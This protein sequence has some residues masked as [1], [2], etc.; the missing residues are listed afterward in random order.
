MAI[1][2]IDGG[3]TAAT[4]FTAAGAACGVKKS[5]ALDIAMIASEPAAK[6][7]AMFTTNAVKAAPV[8][9][10]MARVGAKR[11]GGI[12]ISSGNANACT[13]AQGVTDA[14]R[15]CETA[16][17][18]CG[19][20]DQ[21]FLVASTGVIGTYLPIEKILA[22]IKTT[23][24]LLSRTGHT[25]AAAAIMTTDTVIKESAVEI[26]VGRQLVRI[27]GMAKGVG[28]IA[29]N[30][31]TMI[32][33]VTTDADICR[34][35]LETTI[36]AAVEISFNCVTIDGDMSTNDTVFVLANGAAGNT[37]ILRDTKAA[38]TFQAGLAVVMADLAEQMVRDGEE[39]TKF[40][41]V[42]V[43]GADCY[44]TAKKI[45]MKIAE[46]VLVKCALFGKDANWGRIAAAAGAADV[47]FDPRTMG[48]AING[49]VIMRDG[50]AAID[51]QP[52]L[53]AAMR[54][55]DIEITL[56]LKQGSGAASVLTTDLSVGYVKFNAHYRT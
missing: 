23:G 12:V 49:L 6:A 43:E 30:M 44:G 29:P 20:A 5:G 42:T 8:V 2:K 10:S 51:N 21:E 16:A 15:M 19:K 27:G 22:G 3:V 39:A 37:H 53:D 18:V 31:A 54:E 4:G 35:A 56:D 14:E 24:R 1:K 50:G 25:A 41:R 38:E 32:A 26:M 9:V 34:Q 13:G 48:I 47:E 36:R 28:M 11:V 7:F 55:R 46:S 33:T 17:L 40:V 45:A 52:A